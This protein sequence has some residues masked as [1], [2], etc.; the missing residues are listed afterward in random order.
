MKIS[1]LYIRR[2]NKWLSRKEGEI[3]KVIKISVSGGESARIIFLGTNKRESLFKRLVAYFKHPKA[4]EASKGG[5]Q[6]EE[7]I[8]M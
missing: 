7:S 6:S 1:W 2:F 5:I 8:H 3:M 4:A